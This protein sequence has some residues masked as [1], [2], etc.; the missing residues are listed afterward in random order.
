[1]PHT[2]GR[3]HAVG[4]RLGLTLIGLALAFYGAQVIYS[5]VVDASSATALSTD[6]F[7][8]RASAAP[9]EPM[10]SGAPLL[11]AFDRMWAADGLRKADAQVPPVVFFAYADTPEDANP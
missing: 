11:T 7:R 5:G 9:D 4:W 1:M 10:G 2:G 3:L 6:D 8:I